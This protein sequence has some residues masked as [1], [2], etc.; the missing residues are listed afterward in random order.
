MFIVKEAIKL[1]KELMYTNEH[2]K[3]IISLHKREITQLQN[4]LLDAKVKLDLKP[5]ITSSKQ[6][7]EEL[8]DLKEQLVN[9]SIGENN[10]KGIILKFTCFT[11]KKYMKRNIYY[12]GRSG[13]LINIFNVVPILFLQHNILRERY[14]TLMK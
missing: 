8:F 13:H 2:Q 9:V 14:S 1:N 3:C 7:E 12:S 6:Q 5:E 4:Q 10:S 11:T